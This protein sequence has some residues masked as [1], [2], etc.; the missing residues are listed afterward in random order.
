[1]TISVLL[2]DPSTRQAFSHVVDALNK[3]GYDAHLEQYQ[4]N[5][6]FGYVADSRHKVQAAFWGWINGD[7]T[8]ASL[9]DSWRC[10]AF[11]RG[12]PANHNTSGFCDP[13]FDKLLDEART[14]EA[15]SL[16]QATELW[17]RADRILTDDAPWIPLVTPSWVDVISARVNNDERSP[18][19]GMLFDQMRL[20]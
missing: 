1:M 2:W 15:T 7:A 5:D 10:S 17:A 20:R 19:L 11:T 13:R 8:A 18:V 9:L 14:V 12:D 6:Y 3:L 16:A 4:G